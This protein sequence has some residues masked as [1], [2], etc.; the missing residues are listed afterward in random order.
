MVSYN[1]PYVCVIEP[2]AAPL[3]VS[4]AYCKIL[5]NV[6]SDVVIAD[7]IAAHDGLAESSRILQSSN[8]GTGEVVT[9]GL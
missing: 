8:L 2:G 3:T 9:Y 1:V 4:V 6:A 5:S 7:A